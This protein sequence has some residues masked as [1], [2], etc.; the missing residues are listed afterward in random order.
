MNRI[1]AHLIP[2]SQPAGRADY[3]VVYGEFGSYRVSNATACEIVRALGRVWR[4]T[5]LCFSDLFGSRVRVRTRAVRGVYER[6]ARQ[7]KRHREHERLLEREA[8]ADRNAWEDE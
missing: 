8:T 6:S 4:P 2:E 1:R 5:W 7:R 3:W